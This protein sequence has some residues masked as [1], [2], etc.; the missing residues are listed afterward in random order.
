MSVDNRVVKLQFDNAQFEQGVSQS[1]RTLDELEDKLQFKKSAKGFQSLQQAADTVVF[2]KLADGIDAINKKLSASG[3]LAAK[4]VSSI[5]DSVVSGVKKIEAASIGQIKTGGWNRAMNI[6]NAKFAIQ[7]LKGDWDALSKAIDYSVSGTAYGFD[8]AAK[9]ASTFMASGVDYSKVI[10]KNGT[11]EVTM[12]HKALRAISGVAAQTNSSFEDIS[13]VFTTVAGNGRLMAEQLNSL[14]TRGMNAAAILGEQLKMSEAQVREAVSKGQISF[15]VFAKAMDDAFGEHAKDA[16]KTFTGSFSNM[17]AALSRFGAVFATPIIQKTNTF[18]IALTGKINEMKKAIADVT[19]NGKILEEH[20]ESHFAKMWENLIQLSSNLVSNIDLTWFKNMADG[21]D[22][23]TQK[24]SSALEI[25]NAFASSSSS[26]TSG[27]AKTAY[28][29]TKITQGELDMTYKIIRGEFSNGKKRKKELTK[30]LKENELEYDPDKLQAYVN[31]MSKVGYVLE[32]SGIKVVKEGTEENEKYAR[33]QQNIIDVY[34]NMYLAITN[35]SKS[36]NELKGYLGQYITAITE[37]F[38]GFIGILSLVTGFIKE[39]VGGFMDLVDAI[40]PTEGVLKGFSALGAALGTVIS[41]IVY[42]LEIGIRTV[43]GF[44]KAVL[45]DWKETGQLQAVL[46]DLSETIINVWTALKNI[47]TTVF[48]VIKALATA[49][50]TVF[51]PAR[52][53]GLVKDFSESLASMSEQFVLSEDAAEKLT[54]IFVLIFSVIDSVKNAITGLL[55]GI[56]KFIGGFKKSEKQTDS[57]ADAIEDTGESIQNTSDQISDA[58]EK[59]S[60]L[61]EVA[62][63]VKKW[64]SDLHEALSKNDGVIRMKEAF[65]K[66]GNA[67]KTS[68]KQGADSV[69]DV[70]SKLGNGKSVKISVEDVA[71]AIGWLADKIG[72][73]V[74]NIPGAITAVENFFSSTYTSIKDFFGKIKTGTEDGEKS[75]SF[76]EGV[77]N[78]ILKILG[79]GADFAKAL[80]DSANE[81]IEF[82]ANTLDGI[83]WKDVLES[84]FFFGATFVLVKIA[85][86]LDSFSMAFQSF[87][88]LID[89]IRGLIVPLKKAFYAFTRALSMMSWSFILLSIAAAFLGIA[90]AIKIIAGIDENSLGRATAV[91]TIIGSILIIILLVLR[92]IK[93]SEEKIMAERTKQLAATKGLGQVA[94]NILSVAAVIYAIGKVIVELMKGISILTDAMEKHS[95]EDIVAAGQLIAIIL[96]SLVAFAAIIIFISKGLSSKISKSQ[97][98]GQRVLAEGKV[99]Y[100]LIAAIGLLIGGLGIGIAKLVEAAIMLANNEKDIKEPMLIMMGMIGVLLFGVAAILYASKDVKPKALFVV[101]VVILEMFVGLAILS[102]LILALATIFSVEKYAGIKEQITKAASIMCGV[103]FVM[104]ISIALI[105][106]SVR[107]VVSNGTT[108][109]TSAKLMT[110][111][112][113]GMIVLMAV[114]LGGLLLI[115]KEL[116]NMNANQQNTLVIVSAIMLLSLAMFIELISSVTKMVKKINDAGKLKAISPILLSMG[117]A[118]LMIIGS[119]ALVLHAA[120]ESGIV[121]ENAFLAVLTACIIAI[122]GMFIVVF[123]EIKKSVQSMNAAVMDKFIPMILALSGVMLVLTVCIAAMML[124]AKNTSP[125]DISAFLILLIAMLGVSVLMVEVAKRVSKLSRGAGEKL[126]GFAAAVAA[127]GVAVALLS[128][129]ATMVKDVEPGDI[130]KLLLLIGGVMAL[131][132]IFALAIGKFTA[133]QTGFTVIQGLFLGIAAAFLIFG[134]AMIA[135]AAGITMMAPALMAFGDAFSYVGDQIEKHKGTAIAV[136]LAIVIILLIVSYTILK[137]LPIINRI[138]QAVVDAVK[139][140]GKVLT[141]IGKFIINGISSFG[142][143]TRL[144]KTIKTSIAAMIIAAASALTESGPTVLQKIGEIVLMVLDWLADAIPMLVEKLLQLILKLIFGITDAIFRNINKVSA[145]FTSVILALGAVLATVVRDLIRSLIYG[146]FGENSVTRKIV[147]GIGTACTGTADKFRNMAH[148]ITKEAEEMDKAIAAGGNAVDAWNLNHKEWVDNNTQGAIDSRN[149]IRELNQQLADRSFN[150]YLKRNETDLEKFALVAE[151]TSGLTEDAMESMREAGEGFYATN[152]DTNAE[153]F[154]KIKKINASD[155]KQDEHTYYK[156]GEKL[157]ESLNGGFTSSKGAFDAT[158]IKEDDSEEKVASFGDKL[159]NLFGS[160][161]KK[162]EEKTGEES[163]SNVLAGVTKVFSGNGMSQVTDKFKDS[164]VLGGIS[165][166]DGVDEGMMKSMPDLTDTSKFMGDDLSG[167]LTDSFSIGMVENKDQVEDAGD[168]VINTTVAK[169]TDKQNQEKMREAGDIST[170][171]YT[172]ALMLNKGKMMVAGQYIVDGMKTPIE[173]FASYDTRDPRSISYLG[174]KLCDVLLYT[175]ESN[176]GMDI[177]SPSKKMRQIGNFIVQGLTNGIYDEES[178]AITSMTDLSNMMLNSFTN[179]LDYVKNVANGTYTYDPSIRP[180]LDTSLVARGATGINSL[181]N[182]QNVTL[183]GLS[184]SIAA[185]IGQLDGTNN[186]IIAELRALRRDMTTM[187]DQIAGM[188]VVMDSGRLVGAI[189]PDMD[190]ALG[191]RATANFRGKGN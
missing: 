29:L 78:D 145:A 6:E 49:F 4:F 109:D 136:G 182:H 118:I 150:K 179:P 185:D 75:T 15:E 117:V 143:D 183:N 107:T 157:A 74:E 70:F 64:F 3:V 72:W 26:T 38:G 100:G 71:N 84:S 142:T 60:K 21:V 45:E 127:F 87:T 54:E 106:E 167:S 121:G 148:D 86:I 14:S 40:K 137:T 48:R 122:L 44:T 79:F 18:F 149:N 95:D 113:L 77:K 187:G 104:A 25:M 30:Y 80:K 162:E 171:S 112:I 123:S 186:E 165:F 138:V 5:A 156:I 166:G 7:G 55:S 31:V 168:A 139:V 76:G 42:G 129:A 85:R 53:T 10:E 153:E 90:Y 52:A 97:S 61:V 144:I 65:E 24:L 88:F 73:F 89:A 169:M 51:K 154:F 103:L 115:A 83:S 111:V 43:T 155:F 105:G 163:G 181:F 8:A 67:F 12:M 128:V 190:R 151:K 152:L 69:T 132:S 124:I 159:G 13:H 177:N 92:A 160:G 41:E 62:E 172:R 133:L 20:L 98:S 120:G 23:F 126:L 96:A 9:A 161:N 140:I 68:V 91:V 135:A 125:N 176:R 27:I 180:V 28:D 130:L 102:V 116:N 114:V 35:F 19:E 174:Q 82:I 147:D 189:A 32:K 37:P 164:G 17:K 36:L 170:A 141:G 33:S 22:R 34:M 146:I 56:F 175:I 50:F 99:L 57:F 184:G 93:G 101:A 134:V 178:G 119:L 81:A 66:L 173:Y 188:Q 158:Q 46:E 59:V 2:N 63:K 1:M 94:L 58:T 39:C 110:K 47:G 191:N 11:T 108:T 131:V 16:N